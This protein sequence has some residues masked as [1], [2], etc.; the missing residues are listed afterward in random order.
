MDLF[1]FD[2]VQCPC[3]MVYN[4]HLMTRVFVVVVDFFWLA[5]CGIAVCLCMGLNPNE[6][7]NNLPGHFQ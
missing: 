3:P 7:I 2:F 1:G 5:C 4:K 6:Q